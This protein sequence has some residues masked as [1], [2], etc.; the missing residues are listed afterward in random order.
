MSYSDSA[1]G[2]LVD[3]N[4]VRAH[5]PSTSSATK[6]GPADQNPPGTVHRIRLVPHL[7]S[8]RSFPFEP[9]MR[10]VIESAPPV[11]VGRLAER[12]TTT[13]SAANTSNPLKIAFRSK[14]VARK[15]AEIWV[16]GG[17]KVWFPVLKACLL[18][19]QIILSLVLH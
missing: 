1:N 3:L 10:E 11:R 6:N 14:V 4:H 7:E 5:Q 8:P 16:E 15:H 18:L 2:G 19:V 12:D 13:D 9:I 17:G